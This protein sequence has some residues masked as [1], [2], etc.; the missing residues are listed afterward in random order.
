MISRLADNNKA[1]REQR[2]RESKEDS[3]ELNRII[4]DVRTRDRREVNDFLNRNKQ[5]LDKAEETVRK[6]RDKNYFS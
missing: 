5:Y 2:E 3:E 6:E 4:N 1:I